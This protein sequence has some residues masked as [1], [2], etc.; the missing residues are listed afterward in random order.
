MSNPQSE[1]L[2][3]IFLPIGEIVD[4]GLRIAAM[5]RLS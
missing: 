2:P 5:V 1:I 3:M 4:C